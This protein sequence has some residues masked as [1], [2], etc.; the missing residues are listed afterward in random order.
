M[1]NPFAWLWKLWTEPSAFKGDARGYV[2]NQLGHGYIIGGIPA[3]LWG[4]AA[5]LPVVVAYLVIVEVPQAVLWD[6]AIGDGIE[7]AA[8]VATVAVAVAYGV[9]PALAA[10]ALFIAAGMVARMK[11]GGRNGGY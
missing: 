1:P 8:H 5:V 7:D 11:I 2:L 6:G 4:S 10:H 9:W 3:L